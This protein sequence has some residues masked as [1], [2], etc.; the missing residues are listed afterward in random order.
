MPGLGRAFRSAFRLHIFFSVFFFDLTPCFA[1]LRS[2]EFEEKCEAILRFPQLFEDFPFSFV[3]TSA[4]LKLADIF[5]TRFVCV[6][7][8]VCALLCAYFLSLAHAHSCVF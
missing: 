5:R 7:V 6:C 2:M 3:I 8:C 4:F 1:A